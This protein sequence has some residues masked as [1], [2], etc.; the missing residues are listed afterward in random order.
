MEKG[1]FPYEW[2]NDL[3]KLNS[4]VL[5]DHEQFY[6]I[7]KKSNV[8]KEEYH[9]CQDVWKAEGMKT[10]RDYLIWYDNRDVV[11]FMEALEK[12]FNF[13]NNLHVDM[14]KEGISVP[15]LALRSLF[16]SEEA[17]LTLID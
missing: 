12:Q 1:F 16:S 10:M 9:Y 11:P 5:P 7:L 6:S 2:M 14:F 3:D 17:N 13:Y 15:G 4:Q 8:S